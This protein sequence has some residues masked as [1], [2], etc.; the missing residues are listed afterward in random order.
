[1]QLGERPEAGRLPEGPRWGP[2]SGARR[3]RS[4][5]IGRPSA[6]H[7]RRPPRIPK[8]AFRLGQCG[9]LIRIAKCGECGHLAPGTGEIWSPHPCGARVCTYCGRVKAQKDAAE[10]IAAMARVPKRDGYAWRSIVLTIKGDP[11]DPMMH[12]AEA[13]RARAFALFDAGKHAWDAFLKVEGAGFKL[14]IECADEGHVH[15]HGLSW[16]VCSEGET[17]SDRPRSSAAARLQM[18]VLLDQNAR[19]D[20]AGL[21][22]EIAKYVTKGPSPMSEDWQAGEGRWVCTRARGALGD[23]DDG[24]P[25]AASTARCAR[26]SMRSRSQWSSRSKRR[27]PTRPRSGVA[28][29]V[30]ALLGERLFRV[31]SAAGR[32]D[33]LRDARSGEAGAEGFRRTPPKRE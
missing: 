20:E 10:L 16:A 15:G 32:A 33:Y 4:T 5:F 19:T 28:R 9:S 8:R 27:R 26:L 21:A 22:R 17:R 14:K 29:L 7:S 3:S 23:R 12:T 6:F 18:G 31:G 25:R 1:M 24:R 13:L 11:C 2:G 30:R